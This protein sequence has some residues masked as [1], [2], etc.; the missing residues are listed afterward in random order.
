MSLGVLLIF[1][2][3][4]PEGEVIGEP[5]EIILVVQFDIGW[6]GGICCAVTM[7]KE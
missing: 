4:W 3:L 6:F 1:G 2:R 7:F 5:W